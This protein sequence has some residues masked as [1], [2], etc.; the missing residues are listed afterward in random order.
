MKLEAKI[1]QQE[2]E[3]KLLSRKIQV[4]KQS[5]EDALRSQSHLETQLNYLI[6]TLERLCSSKK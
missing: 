6:S 1:E 4:M 3:I 2:K 5:L